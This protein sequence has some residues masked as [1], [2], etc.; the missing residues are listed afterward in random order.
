MKNL[1]SSELNIIGT[2][3]IDI[4]LIVFWVSN[5]EKWKNSGGALAI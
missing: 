4:K 1:V 5:F 2:Q 3:K